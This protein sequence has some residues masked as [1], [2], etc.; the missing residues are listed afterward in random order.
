[1]AINLTVTMKSNND[2]FAQDAAG[3][4]VARILR[5]LSDAIE[6][7]VEGQFRLGDINGNYAGT[8]FFEVWPEVQG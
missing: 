6:A 2:A 3:A 8:A 4:E 5:A 7:G 1:M